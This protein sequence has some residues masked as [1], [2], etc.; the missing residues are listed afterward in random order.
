MQNEKPSPGRAG[1]SWEAFQEMPPEKQFTLL[2][3]MQ[4]EIDRLTARSTQRCCCETYQEQNQGQ[5]ED[6]FARLFDLVPVCCCTIRLDGGILEANQAFTGLVEGSAP[7]LFQCDLAG[8]FPSEDREVFS[9][10]LSRVIETSQPQRCEMRLISHRG[11]LFRLVEL[12]AVLIQE[13]DVSE[14]CILIV[15]RAIPQD[16]PGDESL[17]LKTALESAGRVAKFGLW[18]VNLAK[19]KV[20]WSTQT[21]LIHEMPPDHHHPLLETAIAYYPEPWR[22]KITDVFSRCAEH[23]EAYDEKMQIVTAKGR[24]IWVQTTGVPVHDETGRIRHVGGMFHDI[25][26]RKTVEE[27]NRRI[28][29]ILEAAGRVAK[30]GGWSV[31]LTENK[32]VLCGEAQA[33]HGTASGFSLTVEQAIASFTPEWRDMIRNVFMRC[34]ET[35]EPFD[36]EA[37]IVTFRGNRI[38][39]RTIGHAI[40]DQNGVIHRIDGALQDITERKQNQAA[41]QASLEEKEVLLREVHHRVKNNLAVLSALVELHLPSV[42]DSATGKVMGELLGRIKSIALVHERLYRHKNLVWIDFQDYLESLLQDVCTSFST[43]C[44]V[45]CLAEAHDVS[46]NLDLAIPCGLIVNELVHNAFK[47]AFPEGKTHDGNIP[48]IQV[49]VRQETESYRLTVEDNGLGYSRDVSFDS[50]PS[51]GLRLVRMIGIHQLKGHF[52]LQRGKGTRIVFHFPVE[53]KIS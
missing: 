37:E 46:L 10:F 18:S 51:F 23:G 35:G 28:K 13:P 17:V 8:F 31:D 15:L 52:E 24:K 42:N 21:A 3:T 19:K 32:I 20:Y 41:L 40:R 30:F 4:A 33:M 1:L 5:K 44:N 49:Y 29:T 14:R 27:E 50:S 22:Q 7:D 53:Q 2:Q 43:Q 12:K 39:V 25:S 11:G 26:E 6:R 16:R 48:T 36:E 45:Q 38:W 47:H 34:R 9:R